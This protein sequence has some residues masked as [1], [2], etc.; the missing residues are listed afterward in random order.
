MTPATHATFSAAERSGAQN[1]VNDSKAR[2]LLS[3]YQRAST[4]MRHKQIGSRKPG[5]AACRG[6][7]EQGERQRGAGGQRTRGSFVFRS[8]LR[9]VGAAFVNRQVGLCPVGQ[10]VPALLVLEPALA[11]GVVPCMHSGVPQG[12]GA[13]TSGGAACK[14]QAG[15]QLQAGHELCSCPTA[16]KR[17]RNRPWRLP[18]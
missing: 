15:R 6:R 3:G 18:P 16:H 11:G 9:G 17:R 14:L 8:E 5:C 12:V 13:T 10:A 7:R 1:L 2:R 4:C